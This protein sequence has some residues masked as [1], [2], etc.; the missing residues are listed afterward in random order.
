M[1]LTEKQRRP[2]IIR[3][4]WCRRADKYGQQYKASCHCGLESNWH[5]EP[6]KARVGL[7]QNHG[8]SA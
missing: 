3:M 5:T 4:R 8:V 2:H 7:L 1:G 6:W